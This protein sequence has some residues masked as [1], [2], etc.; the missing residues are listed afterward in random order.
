MTARGERETHREQW[1]NHGCGVGVL[2]D[3]RCLQERP[4]A[5]YANWVSFSPIRWKSSASQG[6]WPWAAVTKTGDAKSDEQ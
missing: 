3:R 5:L 6:A 2:P 1:L 4:R